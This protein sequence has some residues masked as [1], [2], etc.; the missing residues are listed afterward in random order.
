MKVGDLVRCEVDGLGIIVNGPV[1]MERDMD[2][3]DTFDSFEVLFAGGSSP[4]W[5]A[6]WELGVIN[7]SR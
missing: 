1:E 5:I 7:E 2:E 4:R 6:A 3:S